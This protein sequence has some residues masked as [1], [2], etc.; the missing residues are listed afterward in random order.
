MR[1][2]V[3]VDLPDRLADAVR[4]VQSEFEDASGLSFTDPTQ[5]HITLKFLGEVAPDQLDTVADMVAAGI[6][7]A[8]VDPF[9]VSVEDLGVFPSLE[10]I[11][12]LW[13]GIEQGSA[14]LVQ[15]HEAIEQQAVA[16]GF[17][18]ETH[19]FTPHVTIARMNHAGGKQLVQQTVRTR[20]PDLGRFSAETVALTESKLTPDGP[21]YSTVKSFSL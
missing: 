8:A 15:L 20:T 14:P 7:D 13:V 16:A 3:S 1:L 5:A 12:V 2:F 17:E 11:S 4:A 21:E 9:E 6:D 18:A 10:Y 19:E